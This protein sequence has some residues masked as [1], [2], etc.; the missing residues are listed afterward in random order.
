MVDP[1]TISFHLMLLNDADRM[2]KYRQAIFN[3]VHS[4]DI[5]LDIGTGSGVLALFACQAGAKRVYAIDRGDIIV[6]A[7]ELARANHFSDRIVFTRQ[8]IR[9]F[10]IE[11]Q[12]D[13]ITSELIAKSVLGQNMAELIGFCRD[14]FLKPGGKILPKH[15]Q[16]KIAPV[17]NETNY[18]NSRPPV[19]S[20]YELDFGQLEQIS[21]N[22]PVSCRI[23]S[24]DLLT[25][26]QIAYEYDALTAA[27]S[28]SFQTSL[29]F[30]PARA[31]T[32]HGFVG[33]F[34][35]VLSDGIELNNRPPGT[36]SWDNLFFPLAKSIEVTPE[37]TIELDFRGRCDSQ[38]Q[39]FWIWNTTVSKREQVIAKQRQSS[40]AGRIV[41]AET[42]RKAS[43]NWT[44]L[45]SDRT[46]I[47]Q[48]T[49][50]LMNQNMTIKDI[51]EALQQ[52]F[53][54]SFPTNETAVA[55]VRKIAEEFGN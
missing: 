17:E 25:N 38:V 23:P 15:V 43:D 5:V 39:E 37:I 12:V 20:T 8:D 41:T 55:E 52:K 29:V 30:R 35:S 16:L 26:G 3:T 40:F 13:V 42:L 44:P 45:A 10:Q 28:D 7:R 9:Q 33:W 32:L 19:R 49:L 4:G 18:L 14:R 21:S 54:G 2:D 34:S 27:N 47:A 6:V 46:R 22:K 11:G 36:P 48:M 51:A 31:G 53:P 24:G 50:A 1:Q